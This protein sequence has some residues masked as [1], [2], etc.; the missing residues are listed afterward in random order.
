[1]DMI[2]IFGGFPRGF[3]IFQI[4]ILG[5]NLQ[6]SAYFTKELTYIPNSI[7]EY[8][9]IFFLIIVRFAVNK[10][11]QY[12]RKTLSSILESYSNL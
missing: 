11:Q 12:V 10:L 6:K 2:Y 4:R 5:L 7:R 8:L 9:L 3:P 1:M